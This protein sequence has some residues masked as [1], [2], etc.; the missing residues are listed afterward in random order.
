MKNMRVA[1]AAL[2][3]V[4]VAAPAALAQTTPPAGQKDPGVSA[5]STR[6][7]QYF[8]QQGDEIRASKLVGAPVRNNAD[9]RI[10]EINEVLLKK[11][12]KAAGVVIGVGGFLGIGEREVGLNFDSLRIEPDTGA[13]ATAGSVVVRIDVTK[14]TLKNA[15][16]WTWPARGGEKS[17]TPPSG[18]TPT[19]PPTTTPR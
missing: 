18:Q 3:A 5:G 2:V 12:G 17:P 16:A 19:T 6:Q 4:L 10:G 7:L 11:D 8:T 14:D 15:P 1:L 9:E 13:T